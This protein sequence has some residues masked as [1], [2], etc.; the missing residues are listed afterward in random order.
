MND[1]FC[2]DL[3][4]RHPRLDPQGRTFRAASALALIGGLALAGC[5]KQPGGQVLA[6]VNNEEITQQELRAQAAA[7]NTPATVDFEALAPQLL[8]RVVQRN[9]LADYAR[10]QGLDRGPEFV[11]RRRQME[12]T[13]LA[14]L[15]IRKL[16][17]TPAQPSDEQIQQYIA[18]NP[19]LF[20]SRERLM[21]D[22]L[23][24][25]AP[26]DMTIVRE[27]TKLDNLDAIEARLREKGVAVHRARAGLDTGAIPGDIAKQISVLPTGEIFDLTAD[28]TTI[29]SKIVSR[30]PLVTDHT[31]WQ[32]TA[33]GALQRDM[34]MKAIGTKLEE[35]RQAAKIKY[36][37]DYQ[38]KA[39]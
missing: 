4:M 29:V 21:L 26:K 20:A 12:Q 3:K 8:D 32:R 33:S 2:E 13:L 17:G 10:Q 18:A 39:K 15:A 16:V 7:E 30:T 19:A 35:L 28:G 14:S 38:P 9:L 31:T 34:L 11:A 6:V 36:D 37:A 22:Q 24:F 1:F 27:A 5:N 25:P 23:R